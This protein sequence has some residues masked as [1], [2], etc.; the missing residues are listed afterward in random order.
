[1]QNLIVASLFV[2]LMYD[3]GVCW[4]PHLKTTALKYCN[5]QD[6]RCCCNTASRRVGSGAINLLMAKKVKTSE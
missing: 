2:M 6:R 1:M 5:E 3:V 4:T